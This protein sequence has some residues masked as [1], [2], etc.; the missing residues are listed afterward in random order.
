MTRKYICIP[1]AAVIPFSLWIALGYGPHWKPFLSPEVSWVLFAVVIIGL[2]WQ[3]FGK[4]KR[5]N[6]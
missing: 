3:T 2:A 5:R 4:M 6:K 1:F